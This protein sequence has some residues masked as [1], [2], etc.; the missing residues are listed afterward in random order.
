VRAVPPR[1][2]SV[3]L[4]GWLRSHRRT[5]LGL[6]IAL[7]VALRVVYFVQL[8]AGPCLL[9]HRWEETDMHF[10]DAWAKAI[11]AGDWLSDASP[12]PFLDWHRRIA[13]GYLAVHPEVG[14]ALARDGVADPAAAVYE[15]WAGGKAFHQEPLYP[16][17]VAL[18][19]RLV[20]PD[21]RWVFGWQLASGIALLIVLWSAVRR[22]FDDTVAAVAALL[23][24]LSG[25]LLFQEMV[26]L[27][28]APIACVGIVLVALTLRA[29]RRATTGAWLVL[30]LVLGVGLLLKT[31]FLPYGLGVLAVLAIR[32]RRRGITAAAA[33]VAG[34][35]VALAPAVARNLAVGAP[36]LALSS[37]GTLV[38]VMSNAVDFPSGLGFYVSQHTGEIMGETG[39]R[40][41][42][43]ARATL[44]THPG[45]ASVLAMVAAKL[46]TLWH[47]YEVPNNADFYYYRLQAPVLWLAPVTF[48]VV[49]P[50]ALVGLALG[51][52]TRRTSW[53]FYLLAACH[54]FNLT[55]FYTLGRLR[56]PLLP[57][58]APFA[59]LTLV[60]AAR[61]LVARRLARLAV[62]GGAVAA[63]AVWTSRPLPEGQPL[64]PA[65]DFAVAYDLYYNDALAQAQ[66]DGDWRR[67]AEILGGSLRLEPA[68]V[69]RMGP[70]RHARSQ[71]EADLADLFA[72]V[73]DAYAAVLAPA[74]R[75]AEAAHERRRAAE[76]RAAAAGP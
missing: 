25:P 42:A 36:A 17:L 33:L 28:E 10:F 72:N 74:G 62:V 39:G 22:A 63:L 16:Y 75:A 2:A 49:S 70:S 58:L 26:L 20:G 41:L 12:H 66:Q 11:A 21:V 64:I 38:F 68:E 40:F 37:V 19:Y 14:A 34:V 50:L 54:V 23:V 60:E 35:V 32:H 69:R 29:E 9:Q 18:T 76:L 65:V 44:A 51:A 45:P 73:H 55:V 6:L 67:S 59:A 57:A 13:N 47:W 27:R 5:V 56:V 52:R 7:A 71:P 1:A 30:G 43:A 61:A 48:L 4:D 8:S 53:P 3:D 46:A 15:Q 24:A 31:I